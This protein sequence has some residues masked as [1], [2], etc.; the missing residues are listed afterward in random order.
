MKRKMPLLICDKL[1]ELTQKFTSVS[2]YKLAKKLDL[3]FATIEP[4]VVY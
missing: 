2:P 4:P 1:I 3:V